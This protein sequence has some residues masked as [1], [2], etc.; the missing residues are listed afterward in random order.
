MNLDFREPADINELGSL[1]RLRHTVY[2][3]DPLLHKMLPAHSKHDINQFDLNALHF[4]GFDG[5]KPV[6]YIRMVTRSETL[7]AEWTQSILSATNSEVALAHTPFP[8]QAYCT[9]KEWSVKFV[10]QLERRKIGEVGKLA[11]HKEYRKGGLV[12]NA[13]IQAFIH[14]CKEEQKFE[15]GFGSCVLSLERYYRKFG[16]ERAAGAIPFIYEGLPKA[17]I[18]KFDK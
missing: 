6:A 3:E 5:E 17:V 13:L 9:D 18:V 8:F 2:V 16:F 11:I 4:A 15:T 14:Y 1:F 12:L 7:F 10:E